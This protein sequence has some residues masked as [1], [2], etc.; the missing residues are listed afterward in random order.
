ADARLAPLVA[1]DLAGLG[2]ALRLAGL[3]EA[4]APEVGVG[5]GIEGAEL[6]AHLVGD[7]AGL[8]HADLPL[9]RLALVARRQRLLL[10]HLL[11]LLLLLLARGVADRLVGE[12][13]IVTRGGEGDRQEEG[14]GGEGGAKRR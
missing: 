10:H 6:G 5:A 7:A 12:R 8:G 4:G 9:A 3:D 11:L 1:G 14:E 13:A 2:R